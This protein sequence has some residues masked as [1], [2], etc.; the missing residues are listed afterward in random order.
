[1]SADRLRSSDR[2]GSQIEVISLPFEQGPCGGVWRILKIADV[3]LEEINGREQLYTNH[4]LVH[5]VPL[6]EEYKSRGLVVFNNNWLLVPDPKAFV[7]PSAH[8]VGPEF[9]ET[10]ERRGCI[11]LEDSTC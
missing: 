3:A 7:I 4:D 1:M 9:F 5:N 2:P 8:G 6:M 11:V 10:A